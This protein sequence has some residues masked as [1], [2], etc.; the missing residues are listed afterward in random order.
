MAV[1]PAISSIPAKISPAADVTRANLPLFSLLSPGEKLTVSVVDKLSSNQYRVSFKNVSLTATSDI[2]LQIGEKLQVMV[3]AVM[4]QIVL[5]LGEAQ[6]QSAEMKIQEG[7]IQ[8]RMNPNAL[9]QLF[10]TSGDFLELLRSGELPLNMTAKEM[11]ALSK[12]L[13]DLIL[14][15]QT[16]NHS[17]FVKEFASRLG[18]FMES[19]WSQ[20]VAK[21]PREGSVPLN[22]DSLKASLLK[23][24]AELNEVLHSGSKID[25]ATTGKLTSLAAFVSEAIQSIE[26][27]Q[28]LNVV[29]QQN[30]S[31]I[32]LQIPVAAGE[33][34]RQADIFITPDNKN[35][36]G[37]QKYSSCSIRIF[38]D[39]DYL[40]EISIDA[41][42]REGR[43]RCIIKCEDEDIRHL[44]DSAAGQL[45]KALSGI[46]YGI[47]R[48]DCLQVSEL[49]EKRAE[50]IEQQ[51]L[52]STFLVNQFV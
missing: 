11:D 48:I 42:L 47:E 35:A 26:A 32:Y 44:I 3:H 16:K 52:E 17:L 15:P 37:S 1:T 29:Y 38:L 9:I 20:A 18:L 12:L 13:G 30:E 6:R 28:A 34:M 25:S 2:P 33:M 39:L 22:S 5:S 41:A 21:L 49:K 19:D 50:F 51:L 45:K 40:G 31:G 36:S 7:L 14:S 46:G 43:I 27:R 8:W 23:L 10:Q 24:T 4:P